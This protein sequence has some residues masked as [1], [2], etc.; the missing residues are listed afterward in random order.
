MII[1][2][3]KKRGE[4]L[5]EEEYESLDEK[6]RKKIE[7]IGKTLQEKL[8][9]VVRIGRE[10]EKM[11]KDALGKLEKEA[12]LSA[13]GHLIDELKHK[14]KEHEKITAYL[15]DTREDVLDHLDDFKVQEEQPAQVSFLKLPRAEPTFT[16]YAVNVLVNNKDAKG[17]PCI[18]ES[19]PTFFN[20]FGRLEIR[21]STVWQ[22]RTFR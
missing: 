5:T 3:V 10:S 1:V 21:Y 8:N 20:L 17:A 16:R 22:P 12:A 11:V 2:P 15:E 4:P 14:Y 18:F 7:E 6:T 13:V 19:N 9:D